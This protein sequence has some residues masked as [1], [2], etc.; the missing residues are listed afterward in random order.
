MLITERIEPLEILDELPVRWDGPHVGRRLMEAMQT[1]RL[2]PMGGA[3]GYRPA[4]PAYAYEFDDLIAQ[5][6]QGELERTQAIQNRTRTMPTLR[7]ITA[8][9]RALIWPASYL[10]RSPRI[11]QATN[12]VAL[13]HALDRDVGWV[14]A[15][16]GGYADM[17][18][19]R[20]DRGCEIIASR[21]REKRVSIF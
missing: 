7:A 6:E 10:A 9:E 11:A 15:K 19:Q 14:A 2:M 12:C 8:M 4:W 17:W 21:L 16:R 13:A 1:L 5:H 18:R 20:H 3:I